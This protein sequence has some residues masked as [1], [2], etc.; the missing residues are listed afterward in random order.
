MNTI[1]DTLKK[2]K[3]EIVEKISMIDNENNSMK[4]SITINDEK[5]LELQT[6]LTKIDN[7]LTRESEL[8][9]LFTN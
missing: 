6:E 1:S 9:A 3:T 5:K 2:K 7:F 4:D 8:D